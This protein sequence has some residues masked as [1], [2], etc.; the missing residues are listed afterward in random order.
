M[1]KLTDGSSRANLYGTSTL[2]GLW[3]TNY[4]NFRGALLNRYNS[5]GPATTVAVDNYAYAVPTQITTGSLTESVS[6]DSL[7]RLSGTT[8]PNGDTAGAAY[9]GM[10]RPTSGSSPYGGSM[11]S[12]YSAAPYSA[13]QPYVTLQRGFE[14][15]QY[16]I[17]PNTPFTR[18]TTD[19]L[20][21]PIKV[22]TGVTPS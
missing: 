3:I 9:D 13:I 15:G 20:G 11:S 19:G 7:L 8:G 4:Y 21:R 2:S 17:Y 6:F 18:T 10:G 14:W 22:E 5:G 12:T 16:G 1:A